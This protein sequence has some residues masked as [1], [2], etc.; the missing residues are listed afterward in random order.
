MSIAA[1][2]QRDQLR[3]CGARLNC[4]RSS[5]L[6]ECVGQDDVSTEAWCLALYDPSL[7][8]AYVVKGTSDLMTGLH[9]NCVVSQLRGSAVK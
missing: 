8:S 5:S 1:T 7:L 3:R 9:G 2:V 6:P 4:A